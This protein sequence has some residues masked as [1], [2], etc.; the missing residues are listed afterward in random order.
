[1]KS[2]L[3]TIATLALVSMSGTSWAAPLEFPKYGFQ[4]NALENS[5][6]DTPVQALIMFLPAKNGFA[7]NVNVNI[8][9]Y[10]GTVK[11]YISLS[12]KQFEQ[13]KWK[14]L[15]EK[16]PSANEWLCEYSGDMQQSS[17]HWYARAVLKSGKVYLITG[18]A[19]EDD[20]AD[21]SA[22]LE[23]CVDSFA[24]K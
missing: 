20:W 5:P 24:L 18:T 21:C 8:Q 11:D 1:M 14:V 17:L 16:E 12:K 19:R 3:L 2:R 15:S 6:A 7:P 13:M 4:I 23:K 9:P 22:E 10:G